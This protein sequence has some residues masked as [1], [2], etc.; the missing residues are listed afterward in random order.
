MTPLEIS[1]IIIG[2]IAI[3]VSYFISDKTSEEKLNRAAKDYVLSEE[4]KESLQNQTKAT[5][6]GLLDDL[7]GDITIK[8]ERELE[9]L[10]NEKIIAVK[11]YSD[12]VLDE[13]NK[14]HNEI[15]FLYTMLDDKD[16]ALKDRMQEVNAILN[17]QPSLEDKKN[18]KKIFLE[19]KT[20]KILKETDSKE[21][22]KKNSNEEIL[23]L[24]Q[25]GKSNLDIAK[26]LGIGLG[27]VKLVIDLFQGGRDL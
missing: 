15:M 14:G 10:S 26:E 8:A 4:A 11:D 22:F 3:G 18:D 27:E 7:S 16:K 20:L 2:L 6:E 1:L 23:K 24:H 19:E 21:E 12:L 9:K 5:I 17:E 13:I 25:E